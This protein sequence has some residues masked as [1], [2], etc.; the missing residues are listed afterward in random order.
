MRVLIYLVCIAIASAINVF[1]QENGILLGG[2]PTI[3]L[4][5]AAIA[6]SSAACKVYS[7]RKTAAEQQN[8]KERWYT[9]PK[10]GQLVQEGKPCDCE[11]IAR[12]KQT[13]AATQP[14]QKEQAA[15]RTEEKP[16]TEKPH[17]DKK[18]KGNC[19]VLALSVLS[20]TLALGICV[21]GYYCF[22]LTSQNEDLNNTIQEMSAENTLLQEQVE[23]LKAPVE[24]TF[25]RLT[26]W[27]RLQESGIIHVDYHEWLYLMNICLQE[28]LDEIPTIE[29][30]SPFTFQSPLITTSPCKQSSKGTPAGPR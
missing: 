29:V 27:S 28:R 26:Q 19:A 6:I 16:K 13:V 17:R 21:L 9:C 24:N 8:P 15:Q 11:E 22:H 20:V 4:Y 23:A 5:G 25:A 14:A 7:R 30:T 10:C 2:L 12:R 1:L 3:L 18:K